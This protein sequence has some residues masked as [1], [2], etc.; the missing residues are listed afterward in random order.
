MYEKKYNQVQEKT[1][2]SLI[3][4][5]SIGGFK[6]KQLM[7]K[8]NQTIVKKSKNI[9]QNNLNPIEIPMSQKCNRSI[10]PSPNRED[11]D[12]QNQGKLIT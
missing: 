2:G 1:T 5:D 8:L 4:F 7:D 6:A 3:P 11:N 9:V 12:S 10:L